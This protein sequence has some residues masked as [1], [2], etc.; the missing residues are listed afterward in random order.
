METMNTKWLPNLLRLYLFPLV[1][2][3]A[4]FKYRTQNPCINLSCALYKTKCKMYWL[5]LSTKW[6]Y[7]H[8]KTTRKTTGIFVVTVAVTSEKQ[9]WLTECIPSSCWQLNKQPHIIPIYYANHNYCFWLTRLKPK[10][11][12]QP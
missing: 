9:R 5:V 1:W 4:C 11:T 6:I 8:Q 12:L 10:K 2:Q 3:L 7:M